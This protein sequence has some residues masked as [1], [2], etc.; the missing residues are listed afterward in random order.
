MRKNFLVYLILFLILI[1]GCA[2]KEEKKM[3]VL[4]S[5]IPSEE[6]VKPEPPAYGYTS[7]QQRDPFIPLVSETPITDDKP[8]E[9]KKA[10]LGDIEI[11]A[12]NLS[13]IMWDR[14]ES[15]AML[16]DGNNFGYILKKG[17]LLSDNG[18]VIK[19]IKGSILNNNIVI[20]IQGE[21]TVTFNHKTREK[22]IDTKVKEGRQN[23]IPNQEM[24]GIEKEMNIKK[25]DID[26]DIKHQ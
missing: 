14:K 9:N 4:P 25:I 10:D 7:F 20:L 18:Q 24:M 26:K 21:N 11:I 19:G 17:N 3:V 5:E 6:V 1:V 2:R 12:L 8:T 23:Y 22:R 13:G 15:L 16:H